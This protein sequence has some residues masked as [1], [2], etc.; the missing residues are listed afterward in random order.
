MRNALDLVLLGQISALLSSDQDTN[1]KKPLPHKHS[2]M[3][4]YHGE[5]RICRIT[6]QKLHGIGTIAVNTPAHMHARTHTHN[7]TVQAEFL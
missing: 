4:F 5:A 6:F 3:A 1:A 7:I 2:N